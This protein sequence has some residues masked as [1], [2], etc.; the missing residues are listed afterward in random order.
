MI[1]LGMPADRI[2]VHYTGLDRDKFHTVER[3]AARALLSAMP[4]LGIWSEGPLLVTPGALISRKSH[5]LVIEALA[6]LP[7]ARLA[8]AGTGE[9]GREYVYTPVTNAQL[10]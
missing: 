3:G 2:G 7:D 5:S 8:L 6:H 4:N 1:A 10:V 9:I